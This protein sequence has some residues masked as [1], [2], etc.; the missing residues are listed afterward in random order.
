MTVTF[1]A[2]LADAV[3]RLAVEE[4]GGELKRSS[5]R[6]SD[7]YR[8]E[9]RSIN[10]VSRGTDAVAYA[11][12]RMPATFA[13]VAS[14]FEEVRAR[15][16]GFSPDRLLDIGAGPGTATWAAAEV[17]PGLQSAR[18]VDR[19][20]DFLR[21]ARQLGATV[22]HL[23]LEFD[24]A[25]ALF[26][27]RANV[28]DASERYAAVAAA[29]LLTEFDDAGVLRVAEGL[30]ARTAGVLVIVEPGRPRDYQRLMQVRERLVSLGGD[31]LAPCPHNEPCP[32]VAPDWCHFSQRL[33]RTKDHMRLKGASLGYEDEK[34]SY[35]VVARAGIGAAASGRVIKPTAENKV[36]VTLE[37]CADTGLEQR[38]VP[39]RDK[40][41][42]KA[43]K[44]LDWGD[45][46]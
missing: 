18:L 25:D 11:L 12:S 26:S 34:F 10:V 8:A 31:V 32:L 13:A 20:R 5:T 9:G 44:K 33:A 36:S 30:W 16:P 46:L 39:S 4:E 29:Y 27:S 1:P 43:A 22:P 41:A 17:F 40:P 14:V 3:R 2:G 38:V 35:L 28:A 6:I 7:H 19:S 15:A 42:F 21:L 23:S 45:A 37:V 24:E